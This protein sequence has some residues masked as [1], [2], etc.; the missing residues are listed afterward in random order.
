MSKVTFDLE[1]NVITLVYKS[2]K[3][4]TIKTITSPLNIMNNTYW[5]SSQIEYEHSN[6]N[7]KGKWV[8]QWKQ[9]IK[10]E[11]FFSLSQY[12]P[13]QMSPFPQPR[14][15]EPWTTLAQWSYIAEPSKGT[16]QTNNIYQNNYHTD[17]IVGL[18][19]SITFEI[20]GMK[21]EKYNWN[22]NNSSKKGY[23]YK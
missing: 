20:I 1:H 19:D 2:S 7:I 14:H 22:T 17:C 3:T 11:Q 12:L 16:L 13:W 18:T 6:D 8:F 4:G 21:N 9:H 23:Y 10:N 15:Y 5:T